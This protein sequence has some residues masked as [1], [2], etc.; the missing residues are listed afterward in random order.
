M[1]TRR[2]RRTVNRRE[3]KVF[4]F[5]SGLSS[6]PCSESHRHQHTRADH[7]VFTEPRRTE[8]GNLASSVINAAF[9]EEGRGVAGLQEIPLADTEPPQASQDHR[10]C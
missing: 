5:Q 3:L 6:G 1:R 2:D 7:T 10:Q 4:E 8:L 9:F